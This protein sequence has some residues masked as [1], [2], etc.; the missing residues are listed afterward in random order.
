M[1]S[2]TISAVFRLS[3]PLGD[4]LAHLSLRTRIPRSTYVREAL[5]DLLLKYAGPVG[6]C[7]PVPS[8]PWAVTHYRLTWEQA[9]HLDA[10]STR[11][12]VPKV[13]Y[14]NEAVR[15]LLLKYGA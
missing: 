5:G 13:A 15:D 4:R 1:D 10:L 9:Q 6:D 2:R 7:E 8:G 3:I 12:R 14:L 11:T